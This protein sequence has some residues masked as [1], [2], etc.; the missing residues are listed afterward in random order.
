[1]IETAAREQRIPP[2]TLT[3]GT[4]NGSVFTA[5]A[6]R[7]VLSGLGARIAAAVTA[8]PKSQ[9]PYLIL[10]PLPEGTLRLTQRARA[11]DQ[12]REVMPPNA[13]AGR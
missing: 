12:P 1:M 7:L 6:A 10:A 3:L 9:A 11:L 4:A 5:R 2:G 8:I 13:T